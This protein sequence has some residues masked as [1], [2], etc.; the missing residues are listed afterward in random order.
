MVDEIISKIKYHELEIKQIEIIHQKLIELEQ[1]PNEI[2][3]RK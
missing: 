3:R 2:I 1:E